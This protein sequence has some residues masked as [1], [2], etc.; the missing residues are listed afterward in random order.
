MKPKIGQ[1]YQLESEPI[2]TVEIIGITNDNVAYKEISDGICHNNTA[3]LSVFNLYFIPVK[4]II[5]QL[6]V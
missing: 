5:K 2:H 3:A 4:P 1:I 6:E